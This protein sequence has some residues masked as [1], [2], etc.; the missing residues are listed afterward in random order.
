MLF[1]NFIGAILSKNVVSKINLRAS[2]HKIIKHFSSKIVRKFNPIYCPLRNIILALCSLQTNSL[3]ACLSW[4][5]CFFIGNI[6]I[7]TTRLKLT[8]AKAK[9]IKQKLNSTPRLN[10]WQKC[11]NK[12]VW[13]FWWDYMI[14]CNE[15]ENDNEK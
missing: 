10:F 11:P 15:N 13:L 1:L 4:A 7:S 9:S 2:A 6:F 5:T 14:N 12:L 3:K 8:K